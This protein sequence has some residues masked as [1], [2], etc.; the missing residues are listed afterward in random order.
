M[1]PRFIP[2]EPIEE[3]MLRV[4]Y[5]VNNVDEAVEFYTSNLNFRVVQQ[6]GPAIAI[7]ARDELELLVSGPTASGSRAMPDGTKPT[8]GGWSRF[9]IK[10]DDIETVVSEL[11]ERGV[12]FKN[13][14]IKGPGGK[15]ILCVDPSG[16]VVELF[17][18]A[19]S[20]PKA[21]RPNDRT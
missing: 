3:T 19:A 10:V 5:I 7:L 13:E 6:F 9:L 18:P 15:Q 2:K 1:S 16:N 20:P 17:Q 8:P 14:I 11:K 4:R 12:P 21:R